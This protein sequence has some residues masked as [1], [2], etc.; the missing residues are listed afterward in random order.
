MPPAPRRETIS[1]G[2]S[3]VPGVRFISGRD[4][5]LKGKAPRQGKGGSS[6]KNS[7]RD[8]ACPVS[9][10]SENDGRARTGRRGFRAC[11]KT[12]SCPCFWVAQR[13]SA[14]AKALF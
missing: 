10:P 6:R 3:L 14:A 2:P 4:Y 12:T 13:F 8:G 9:G 1:Y 11:G 5:N 7:C